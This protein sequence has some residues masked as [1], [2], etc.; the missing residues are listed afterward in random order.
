MEIIE[1]LGGIYKS[2]SCQTMKQLYISCVRLILECAS[3]AWYHKLVK[4]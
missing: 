3:P 4:E 2:I 1:N